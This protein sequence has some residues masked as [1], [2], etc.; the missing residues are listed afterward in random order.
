MPSVEN[1]G[2]NGGREMHEEGERGRTEKEVVW[3]LRQT[4]LHGLIMSRCRA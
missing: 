1:K 3:R 4:E 2:R